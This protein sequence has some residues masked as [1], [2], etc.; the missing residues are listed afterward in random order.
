MSSDELGRPDDP[1]DAPLRDAY[2][3]L[4]TERAPRHLD[5]AVLE[6]AARATQTKA[7]PRLWAWRRPLAWMTMIGLTVAVVL[8]FSQVPT[9]LAPASPKNAVSPVG[10]DGD[11]IT[12]PAASKMEADK[13]RRDRELETMSAPAG[14]NLDQAE[15]RAP[16]AVVPDAPTPETALE[17]PAGSSEK[18]LREA[19]PQRESL[20]LAPAPESEAAACD[21]TARADPERWR[22]CIERLVAADRAAEAVMETVLYREAFPDAPMPALVR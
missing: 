16:A 3:Q 6:Q 18:R 11:A 22:A 2:R 13:A 14:A 1:V 20:Y 8:E 12:T 7:R 9:D 17:E 15:P 5:N 4:A 10:A 19:T 21:D